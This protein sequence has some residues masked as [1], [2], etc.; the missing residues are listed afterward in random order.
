MAAPQSDG[1]G[2]SER[3][4]LPVD[5][6]ARDF[7]QRERLQHI[8]HHRRRP[9]EKDIALR[10][11]WSQAP[12]LPGVD[13]ASLTRPRRRLPIPFGVVRAL[14]EVSEWIHVTFRQQG[15]PLI[16]VVGVDLMQNAKH[17]SSAK[18]ERELGYVHGSVRPAIERAYDWFVQ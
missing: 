17:V 10:R 4:A 18:A 14:A 6:R 15:P 12:D 2:L 13:A 3:E 7:H 1:V 9:A 11:I 8:L 16:P 5:R